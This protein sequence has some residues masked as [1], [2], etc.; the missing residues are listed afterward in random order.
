MNT[1]KKSNS[2]AKSMCKKGYKYLYGGKGEDYTVTLV[3]KLSTLYPNVYSPALRS[4][5][6]KDADKGYK[7][8]DCSGFVCTVLGISQ[9]GSQNL[10][11]ECFKSYAVDIKNAKEGM[12]IWKKGHIAYIGEG[13][14]IYE[15][16]STKSDMQVHEFSERAKGFT[17]LL[18]VKGSAL[19]KELKSDKKVDIHK[20][21]LDVIAGKYG[22]GEKRK[23]NLEAAGYDYTAVQKEVNRILFG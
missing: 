15:A 20:I 17:H 18:V 13:L 10:K 11:D 21:A 3:N 16:A 12:A 8:I 23:K 19:E 22:N 1:I 4:E 5:A 9:K 14:K 6:L 2:L 7:A